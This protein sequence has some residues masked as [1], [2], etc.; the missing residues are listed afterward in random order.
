[1]LL[2][3]FLLLTPLNLPKGEIYG[4]YLY[5]FQNGTSIFSLHPPQFPSHGGVRGGRV[6]EGH[7]NK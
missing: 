2:L 1:M 6:R 5:D 4:R 3:K 7:K